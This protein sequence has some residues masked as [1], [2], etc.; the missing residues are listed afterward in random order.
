MSKICCSKKFTATGNHL[1][2]VAAAHSS[3]KINNDKPQAKLTAWMEKATHNTPAST[4][5]E[6]NRD[7]V[8]FMCRKLEPFN[9]VEKPGFQDFWEKNT[10]FTLPSADTVRATALSDIY[11]V[12][13]RKVMDV[14]SSCNSGTLMMDGRTDKYHC[15]LYFAFPM[16]IIHEWMF[17]VV[18]FSIQPLASHV[19]VTMQVRSTSNCWVS[20]T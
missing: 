15:N 6:F 18:T 10:S 19:Y 1:T 16:S 13:K 9:A 3:E 11:T 7:I 4:Q 2:H 8:V 14:F 5:Y 20:A 12:T 17:K